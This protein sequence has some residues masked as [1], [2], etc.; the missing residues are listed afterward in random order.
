MLIRKYRACV[1]IRIFYPR[2]GAAIL[3]L[4]VCV[5]IIVVVAYII[6]SRRGS[7]GAERQ[8]RQQEEQIDN[9]SIHSMPEKA[10]TQTYVQV[11]YACLKLCIQHLHAHNITIFYFFR[12]VS[13]A[14]CEWY[15]NGTAQSYPS[16]P[17]LWTNIH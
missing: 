16:Y 5:L 7:K 12:T 13:R 10:S 3:I 2:T 6:S 1:L 9:Y 8:W 4:F 11:L 14:P 15:R 17:Q